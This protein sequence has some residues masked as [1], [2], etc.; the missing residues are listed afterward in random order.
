M[1]L[2]S[3]RG[4]YGGLAVALHWASAAA[5]LFLLPS[6]ALMADL[7]GDVKTTVYR[8]HL[9]VGASVLLMTLLRVVWRRVDVTPDA[10]PGLQGLHRRAF[11]AVHALLYVGLLGASISGL[12]LSIQSGLGESLLGGD[13]RIPDDLWDYPPRAG[14]EVLAWSVFALLIGHL[15]GVLLH[16][17][18]R[19]DT[20]SRMGV[21]GVPS[22][23][24]GPEDS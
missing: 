10:P 6:G 7:E 4:G 1:A 21:R 24:D 22:A 17:A 12:A 16:Q 14:H 18:T 5:L 19:G 15:G 9:I 13:G 3:T 11:D 23:G 2:R 20:L 8:A